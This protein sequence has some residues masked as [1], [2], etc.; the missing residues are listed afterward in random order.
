MQNFKQDERIVMQA[1]ILASGVTN[2]NDVAL[3][4]L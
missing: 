3:T 1:S 2:N 4:M